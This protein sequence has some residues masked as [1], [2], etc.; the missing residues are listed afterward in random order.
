MSPKPVLV[1]QHDWEAVSVAFSRDGKVLAAGSGRHPVIFWDAATGKELRRLEGPHVGDNVVFSPDGR[2]LAT[3]RNWQNGPAGGNIHLWDATT[4]KAVRDLRGDASLVR[5]V[6]FYPDGERIASHSQFGRVQVWETTTGRQVY[7]IR[8]NSAGHTVAVSPDGRVLAFD[9]EYGIRLCDAGTGKELR[10][11][12]G[13]QRVEGPRGI[14]SGYINALTFSPDGRR[15][16][17]A[18]CDNMARIWDV[19]SGKPLQVLEGHKGF[20]NAVRFLPGAKVLATGGEDGTIRL[21]DVATGKELRSIQAH[22]AGRRTDGDTRKD[23]F[24]L[25]LSPDG[26]RLASAGRDTFVRVWDVAELLKKR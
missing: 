26:K 11:M 5:A 23:I 2:I 9:V 13:H 4:A 21:W 12:E 17:S 7:N 24:E 8:T 10:R 22:G 3:V 18:S 19:A 20:V 16:A 14:T 15:L 6:A 25:A 1:V